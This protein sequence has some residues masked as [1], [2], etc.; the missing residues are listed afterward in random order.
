MRLASIE[1]ILRRRGLALGALSLIVAL[2]AC[3][4]DE[5][6]VPG[7]IGPSETG[8]SLQMT[9]N[10]DIV[11]ADGVSQSIVRVMARD[12]NGKPAAG[13]Q[14]V[15]DFSGDGT[16]VAGSV[17]VGPLQTGLSLTTDSNGIAQVAY[18]AGTSAGSTVTIFA[19]P[20]GYDT[21]GRFGVSVQIQLR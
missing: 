18:V 1:K 15:I 5:V 14:L 12:Q 9:A 13:R 17:L 19:F 20:Y 3:G 11:S 6:K 10:P 21:N 7:L 16:I 4:L 2:N 8:L